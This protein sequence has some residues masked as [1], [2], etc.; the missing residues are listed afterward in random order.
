[1]I[2]EPEKLIFNSIFNSN[3]LFKWFG[4]DSWWWNYLDGH[5]IMSKPDF[6]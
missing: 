3:Y 2:I 5:S 1:L 6:T 4:D